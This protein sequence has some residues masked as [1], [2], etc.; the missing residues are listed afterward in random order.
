M[1]LERCSVASQ[2]APPPYPHWF[3]A[4]SI[5]SS[6]PKVSHGRTPTDVLTDLLEER[7]VG[8]TAAQA[9]HDAAATHH[10]GRRHL[11]QEHA[12]CRRLTFAQRVVTTT[13]VLVSLPFRLQQRRHRQV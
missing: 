11:D 7:L 1:R 12:P 4:L 2:G 6:S 10:H 3:S 13:C 9:H 8:P 5:A